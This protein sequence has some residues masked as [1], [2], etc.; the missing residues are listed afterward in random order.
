MKSIKLVLISAI[1]FLL[2]MAGVLFK[3][4]LTVADQAIKTTE[5]NSISAFYTDSNLF[6]SAL[7]S[8]SL[9]TTSAPVSGLIVPHH[10]LAQ[11]LTAQAFRTISGQQ[12]STIVLLS[13]DH[14]GS[15]RS[16]I[17][18]T[19]RDFSTV[20]GEVKTNMAI[21]QKLKILSFVSEGDFFY[22][23]HGLQA[24]LPFIK[25]FFPDAQVVALTFQ[26]TVS[27]F[28]LDQVI[29]IL[30]AELPPDSLIIQ[31]TD[32]SHY[33]SP[34]QA[35]VRDAATVNV[36][37]QGLPE[38]ILA[39]NQP[40]NIDSLAAAYVQMSLQKDFFSSHINILDQRNSQDYTAE[41]VVS[42]T[43]YITA[44]YL[45][46]GNKKATGKAELIF[47]GDIMLSRYIG[48]MMARRQDYNFPY[49]Q[50]K[51]DL[52]AADLVVANLE[53]PISN[54]GKSAGHLYSF[55]ADPQVSQRLKNAGINVLSIANNHV[56]D[57]GLVAFVDTLKNLKGAGLSYA[58]GGINFV[59]A[60]Q[61]NYQ[62]I[63]GVKIT[64][65]A[66]TDLLPQS[67]AAREDRAG[68]TYLDLDQMTRD[69]QVAKAKSDLV[70][71]SFHWGREY[72]IQHNK[73]QE[74]VAQAAIDAGAD[75]VVGHHP[76]VVQ[77]IGIYQGV[78]IAYSLGNFIFDQNFKASDTRHGLI[79]KVNVADK[80]IKTVK[81]QSINFN[82]NYQPIIIKQKNRPEKRAVLFQNSYSLISS[83]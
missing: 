54:Q 18:T 50:I 17:S 3:T 32:F 83:I 21:A 74:K 63:N 59:E 7:K 62:E 30:A 72:E 56:F 1:I 80:K 37:R 19:E 25:Y 13:P 23:E 51:P 46:D 58:G 75:L 65:L 31:S 77:D 6:L 39:L 36:L 9:S 16:A 57:Y 15:G 73:S 20:F 43:S 64:L 48:E 82:Q 78:S 71:V 76:H 22:R 10:L 69:I 24:E 4:D 14:F 33:L 42:S 66:Y 27:R 45:N 8:I 28:E 35:T 11:D 61:G 79:L 70:L 55:R 41:K 53:G 2:V 40:D 49:A 38:D 12:Y 5:S 81:P 34:A 29:K 44:T 67:E 68:F 60:H 26:P 47:V 52:I